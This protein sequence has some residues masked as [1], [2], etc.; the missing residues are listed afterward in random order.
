MAE[1]KRERLPEQPQQAG[2]VSDDGLNDEEREAIAR[3]AARN[4]ELAKLIGGT[5]LEPVSAEKAFE[6]EVDLIPCLIPDRFY[7]T[8]DTPLNSKMRPRITFEPGVARI[9]AR[10]IHGEDGKSG[11]HW[12]LKAH[13]VKPLTT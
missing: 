12:W 7:F 11:M 5:G 2:K 4:A 3:A 9:P 10:L 13:K 6:G 1:Q 8:P